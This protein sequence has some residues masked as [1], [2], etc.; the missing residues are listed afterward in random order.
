MDGFTFLQKAL[1]VD[2]GMYVIL[3]TGLYA[4]DL[5]VEAI[6]R[7]AYDYIS[8]PIDF[9]RLTKTLD[10]L[11]ISFSQRSA[12][13]ELEERLL[14]NLQFQGIVGRSPATIEV[15]E[16]PRRLRAITRTC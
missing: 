6:K 2:P 15:F 12:I 11:A 3:A 10:E 16:L 5:A 1:Q 8:K 9:L 14:E 4:V 7:G 13:R